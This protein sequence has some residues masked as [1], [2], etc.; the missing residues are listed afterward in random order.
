MKKIGY[1]DL[2]LHTGKCPTWLFEKMVKLGRSILLIVYHEFGEEELIKRITD[3]FWFQAFGCV[4]GFDWHSSGLT[5]TVG[6]AIKEALKPYFKDLKIYICGGK[7]QTALKTPQEINYW[8]EKHGFPQFAEKYVTLSRLVARIDNNAIQ[9]GF[10]L[11]FHLMVFSLKGTWG[12][13]QQGMDEKIGYAR[14][15]HWYSEKVINFFENPHSG[16]ISPIKKKEVLNLV[17]T[18]SKNVQEVLVE[19]IKEDFARIWKEIKSCVSLTFK[20]EHQ[21]T[22][23]DLSYESLRKI[24]EVTYHNPPQNFRDLL[25]TPGMGAKALRALTLVSELIYDVKASRKD[26]V[27]Y[28]YAHGGKDG[29]P[30]KLNKKLYENTIKELEEI[31]NQLKLPYSEKVELFRTLYRIF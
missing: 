2:P 5:T 9:D 20:K 24:W 23:Q 3:P 1:V 27:I 31:L 15:Y 21:I 18:D 7:G 8:A 16:I 10:Q 22:Y 17:D 29:H 11:Y 6:T 26:P 13:I 30:Y 12:V 19:M 25:L 28:S 14:R 4:L